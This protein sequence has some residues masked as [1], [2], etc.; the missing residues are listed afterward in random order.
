MKSLATLFSL[1]ALVAVSSAQSYF[2]SGTLTAS[3]PT[4]KRPLTLTSYSSVG[5][6]CAYDVYGF[7]VSASG[8]YSAEVDANGGTLDTYLLIYN[9]PFN[10]A[11]GVT[12]LINGDDDY[13]GAF[14]VLPGSSVTSTRASRISPVAGGANFASGGLSLTAGTTYYAVVSSFSN[15]TVASG[16]GAYRLGIGGGP[17]A[18]S[19]V[20]EPASMAALGLGVA[21]MLRR[22]KKA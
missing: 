3:D 1:F 21:A 10:P 8:V 14:S 6:A 22:R 20:P 16:L 2:T 9:G 13:A 15:A 4:F 11:S 17:G 19:A 12:N 7:K 5:T 18:V